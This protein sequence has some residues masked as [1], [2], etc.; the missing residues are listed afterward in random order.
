MHLRPSMVAV[1]CLLAL[2]R[3]AAAQPLPEGDTGIA[4]R[5]PDDRGIRADPDV[6]FAEDFESV[7]GS[8]LAVNELWSNVWGLLGIT[9]AGDDVHAGTRALEVT[10]T[11]PERSQGAVHDFGTGGLDL[12]FVRY[13]MK[14][15][16]DF[17]GMHHTGIDLFAGAP[18]VGQGD[19][20]GVRPDGVRS[21][22]ALLDTLSP[23]FDWSPP[24]N[25]PPGL[26]E[27]YCYHKDQLGDYGDIFYSTGEGNGNLALFGDTFVPRPNVTPERG[28][29]TSFELMLKANT[30]GSRD[31]RAAFWVD[32]RLA[33]DFPNLRFRTVDALRINQVIITTYV[34][35]LSSNQTVWYDD[36]IA[37]RSYIGP[38][39]PAG[40]PELDD[41]VP[42][43]TAEPDDGDENGEAEDAGDTGGGGGGCGC[44]I[45]G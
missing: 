37:A 10:A 34:S 9:T 11:E 28:R 4:A 45:A 21:F 7:S 32:G 41:P 23:M 13:Y 40:G 2:T 12:L 43:T 24:G 8:S 33:G 39:V 42:D 20:T 31:G 15:H 18:G 35:E 3:P 1:A 27:V 29:W 36:I 17:P 25:Q 19:A 44:V 38:M 6:V 16:P 5:Y 30:P 14:Y 26:L 22:Q